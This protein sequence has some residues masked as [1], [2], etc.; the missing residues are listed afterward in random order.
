MIICSD[1]ECD[2]NTL[3]KLGFGAHVHIDLHS[4]VKVVIFDGL[5]ESFEKVQSSGATFLWVELS[6][7][8]LSLLNGTNELLTR[9]R[10][11][12]QNPVLVLFGDGC[13]EGVDK[14]SVL[15]LRNVLESR[16]FLVT[17]SSVP[18]NVWYHHLCLVELDNFSWDHTK[19]RNGSTRFVFITGFKESLHTK[20][21]SEERLVAVGKIFLQ[22]GIVSSSFQDLHRRTERTYAWK[23]DGL[24]M[25]N[26]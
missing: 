21:N 26:L 4:A 13:I 15:F 3:C 22:W 19:S 2:N 17:N 9:I 11:S 14:V 10:R 12:C 23:D 6:C 24:G 16:T 25:G 7:N 1:I 20:T 8:N 18:S 5:K